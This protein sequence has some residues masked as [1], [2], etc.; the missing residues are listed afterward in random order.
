MSNKIY[1]LNEDK[2]SNNI[3]SIKY[4]N[5]IEFGNQDH[6]IKYNEEI[7]SPGFNQN[8]KKLT[9]KDDFMD[10]KNKGNLFIPIKKHTIHEKNNIN[11]KQFQYFEK[12]ECMRKN[13]K[14]SSNKFLISKKEKSA[15]ED[16]LIKMLKNFTSVIPKENFSEDSKIN[17][18]MS[19]LPKDKTFMCKIV[20]KFESKYE[21]YYP[22]YYLYVN[23]NDYYIMC[24][25]KFFTTFTTYHIFLNKESTFIPNSNDYL[26]KVYSNIFGNDF[27]I[28]GRYHNK[29]KKDSKSIEDFY[30]YGTVHYVKNIFYIRIL[31]YLE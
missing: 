5:L 14:S 9:L 29:V 16:Q 10:E 7:T 6:I 8:I 23:N 11:L 24:A 13:S 25:K 3:K 21:K 28:Y 15:K 2:N 1:S 19:P 22:R 31:I 4:D 20:T 26:G 18:L 17:F 30:N 27:N 12:I